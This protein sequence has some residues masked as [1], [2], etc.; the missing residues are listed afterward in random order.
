MRSGSFERVCFFVH[1]HLAP[2]Q[3]EWDASMDSAIEKAESGTIACILVFTDGGAPNPLQRAR[4]TGS[5]TFASLPLAVITD[6]ALVRGVLTALNW[7]GM[8]GKPFST[9]K[10]QQA[11]DHLAVPLDQRDE[12]LRLV[13]IQKMCL[14]EVGTFEALDRELSRSDTRWLNLAIRERV[15]KLKQNFRSL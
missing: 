6:S 3:G 10:V 14:A 7:M 12:L 1:T 11:L 9:M 2:D 15:S 5:K 8:A 4:I 13:A